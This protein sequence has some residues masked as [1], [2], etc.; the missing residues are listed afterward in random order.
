MMMAANL[1]PLLHLKEGVMKEEEKSKS[2]SSIST[3]IK[4]FKTKTATTDSRRRRRRRLFSQFETI[5]FVFEE[6]LTLNVN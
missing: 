5:T 4:T 3:D 6:N 2:L 1:S